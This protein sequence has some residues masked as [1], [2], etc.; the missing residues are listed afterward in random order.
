MPGGQ[1]KIDGQIILNALY[2][3][4]TGHFRSDTSYLFDV[5][6]IHATSGANFRFRWYA[7]LNFIVSAL[8]AVCRREKILLLPNII[9]VLLVACGRVFHVNMCGVPC[10]EE[11][12]HRPPHAVF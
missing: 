5:G 9:G 2:G 4:W 10:W 7:P 8:L 1:L 12:P 6:I 3:T 11:P